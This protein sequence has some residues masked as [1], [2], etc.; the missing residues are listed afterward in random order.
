MAPQST[1]GRCWAATEPEFEKLK[2]G[3][4]IY[5]PK[6]GNGRPRVKQYREEA[7]GLSR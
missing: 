1:K 6:E 3:G 5:W 7:K 4:R 2:T